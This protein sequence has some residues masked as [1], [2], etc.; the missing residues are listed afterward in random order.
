MTTKAD[1][2]ELLHELVTMTRALQNEE[3]ASVHR[4]RTT[5][6]LVDELANHAHVGKI[7]SAGLLQIRERI[8]KLGEVR[9][10]AVVRP[11]HG[12]RTSCDGNGSC[13][14]PCRWRLLS[15][16]AEYAASSSESV[17]DRRNLDHRAGVAQTLHEHVA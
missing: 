7:A 14:L 15:G 9:L 2:Q 4:L 8:P 11:P 17:L 1:E 12:V 5:L 6:S 3:P 13:E 10:S 16:P